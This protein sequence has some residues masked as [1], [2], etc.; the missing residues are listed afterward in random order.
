ME[1]HRLFSF[2]GIVGYMNHTGFTDLTF[3]QTIFGTLPESAE[4]E[5]AKAGHGEG[6]FLVIPGRKK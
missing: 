1:A 2:E 6:F 4:D 5:P 3:N